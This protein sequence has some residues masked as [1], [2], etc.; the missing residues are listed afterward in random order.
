MLETTSPAPHE[1]ILNIVMGFWQSRALAVATELELADLLADGPLHTDTL[2]DR[3]KTDS[4]SLFRLM[5]ALE[6]IGVFEQVSPCVFANTAASERLRKS[7]PGSQW[8]LVRTVLSVGYGQYEA[9]AGLLDSIQTGRPAFDQIF[10]C[11]AWEWYQRDPQIRSVFNETMQSVSAAVTPVV[12]AS[13]DWGRFPLIADIGG[14]VGDQLMDIL[15]AYPSC[16]GLLF[17]QPEVVAAAIRHERVEPIAGDFFK[18]APMG[19]DAYVLRRILHDWADPEAMTILKNV[20]HAMKPGSLLVLIEEVVPDLPKPTFGMWLDPHMLV[21]HGGQER[22]A[23]EY[24]ELLARCGF[25][26]E[27]IVQTTSPPSLI[28]GRPRIA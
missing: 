23:N 9:W 28:I 13:Y 4:A 25:E 10:G 21:I 2:A 3:T 26:L 18:S 15:N 8:A 6:S 22:T 16:R 12:T 14:G 7:V 5:R 1:Q 17:D 19:A 27:Q 24:R 20:H 11:S